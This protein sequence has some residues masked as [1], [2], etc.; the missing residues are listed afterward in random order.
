MLNIKLFV[1]I[2]IFFL[3]ATIINGQVYGWRGPQRN[4]IIP[5]TGLLKSWPENGPEMIWSYQGLGDGHTSIGPAKDR[6]FITGL[7]DGTG[8]LFAFDYNGKLLWKKVYGPE[9][10]ENYAGPRS[11]PVVINDLVYFQSGHGVIYCIKIDTGDKVWSVD[12]QKKFDGRKVTWGMVENLLIEGDRIF[13][14]PGGIKDNVAALNR[15][16]GETIWTSPGNKKPSAYCSSIYVRHNKAELIVTTT[17]GSIIGIDAKTGQF[18]WDIPQNQDNKIHANA[19]VY[20]DGIIYCASEN[21]VVNNGLVAL[22]LSDDGRKVTQLWRNQEFKNLM[23]GFILRDG[24]IYGS[25]YEAG[26]WMCVDIDNGKTIHT[27]SNFGDGSILLADGL[28]YCYSKRGEMALMSADR[29]A[30]NVISRFRI[31]MGEGPH[32][33]HPVIYKGRLYVRHGSVLMVYKIKA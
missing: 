27:F 7:Q 9:W 2:L 18:Y 4:G 10:I 19:P 25:V 28:F 29:N 24:L 1:L 14:T 31:P 11:T 8:M 32:F 26:K 6:F 3:S 15:F 17:D 16:T 12:L 21:D 5:E 30:F 13:C 20:S 23:E 22:K 33:S